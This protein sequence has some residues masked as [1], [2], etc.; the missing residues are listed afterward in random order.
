MRQV[1]EGAL[2]PQGV[3]GQGAS[4]QQGDAFPGDQGVSPALKWNH[5]VLSRSLAER[6]FN[7]QGAQGP[8]L[9]CCPGPCAW[10]VSHHDLALPVPPLPTGQCQLMVGMPNAQQP[11]PMPCSAELPWHWVQAK[12]ERSSSH[13]AA[14][15]GS[16][17]AGSSEA[18]PCI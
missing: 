1:W 3:Q 14:R 5:E 13:A 12:G 10:S 7:E 18:L 4:P 2:F 6:A 17:A 16:T 15:L 9:P 8:G 11:G